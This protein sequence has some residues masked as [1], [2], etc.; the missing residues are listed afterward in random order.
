MAANI[1]PDLRRSATLADKDAWNAIVLGGALESQGMIGWKKFL[2]PEGA[3][4]I[5][6]YVADEAGKLANGGA[7]PTAARPQ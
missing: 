1:I 2:S 6:A 5:R 4:A 7:V 3:E